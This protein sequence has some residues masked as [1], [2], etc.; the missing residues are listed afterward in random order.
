MDDGGKQ[1]GHK[2]S[3]DSNISSF[4]TGCGGGGGGGGD[5]LYCKNSTQL[6][7]K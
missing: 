6:K 5:Y 1:L 4:Y 2:L 7:I 3:Q